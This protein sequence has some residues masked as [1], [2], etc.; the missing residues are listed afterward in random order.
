MK[1][2]RDCE[3]V[4]TV[5]TLEEH[6]ATCGFT[7][8]PCPK[9]CKDDKAKIRRVVKKD[10]DKHLKNDCPNRD[11]ECKSKCGEKGT[12][13]YIAEVHDKLC[14]KKKL[15]CPNAGCNKE[16]QRQNISQHVSKC[17]HTLI[18]CKYK[19]IGCDTELKRSQDLAAHEQDDKVHLH[20]ALETV[21]SL[22]QTAKS[23]Q[24]AID[25]LQSV[26]WGK[27]KVFVLLE[28]QKKKEA[29]EKFQLPPFY[30]HPNGYHMALRVDGNGY[31]SGVRTHLSVFACILE[32]E[33]DAGLK[34][35]FVGEVTVTLMNQL[36]DKNHHTFKISYDASKNACIGS[37]WGSCTFIT[38]SALAHNPV[39]NTQ[40]LKD[41]ALY[42]RVAVEVTGRKRWLTN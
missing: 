3:W 41:D 7:L 16:I 29:N 22:H 11:F 37:T 42:F 9:L 17:P 13:T 36:E 25:S 10:L 35:P 4:G 5:G 39:R 27:S 2:E 20:M 6:V 28:Y 1:C 18:P 15:P 12:F 21:N 31:G 34:W 26:S 38:Y 32:G 24:A 40:Y 33:Y 30:T 19:G 8:V 14:K 23:Q